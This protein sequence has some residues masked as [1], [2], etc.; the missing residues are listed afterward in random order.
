MFQQRI[1]LPALLGLLIM[2]GASHAQCSSGGAFVALTINGLAPSTVDPVGHRVSVNLPAGIANFEISDGG[3]DSPLLL[4]T[5]SDLLCGFFPVPWG[6][7]IDLLNPTLLLDGFTGS[8]PFD[9]AARTDFT[10]AYSSLSC[11][12]LGV[13]GPAMQA[14]LQDPANSPFFLNHSEAGVVDFVSID[15]VTVYANLGDDDFVEH[16][17]NSVCGN[18]SVT[19]GGVAYTSMF[20]NSNGAITFQDGST[21]FGGDA[22]RFFAGFQDAGTLSPNPGIA[23]LWGDF[24]EPG[25]PDDITVIE[26]ADGSVE[27]QFNNQMWWD[28]ATSAGSWTCRLDAPIDSVILDMSAALPGVSGFDP[29]P[30]TG[31]SDGD[32][33]NGGT[34]SNVDF[35]SLLQ[36][37]PY[38]TPLN[39]APESIAEVFPFGGSFPGQPFD[40]G[41]LS[42]Q[43]LGGFNWLVF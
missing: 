5:G 40:L 17:V 41:L 4:V 26:S 9:Q 7:S 29:D 6:G 20:L 18:S 28:S 19:F 31:V 39:A 2:T 8:T 11:S 23:T 34:D 32:D 42:F 35:S 24:A 30:I 10:L 36:S 16:V 14:I 33:S 37:G 21:D 27:V 25:V 43:H 38:S 13:S 22:D 15:V 1:L 3:S 12:L